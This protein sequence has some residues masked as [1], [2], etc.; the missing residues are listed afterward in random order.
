MPNEGTLEETIKL[1]IS[2]NM[3]DEV[4]KVCTWKRV[5]V[6]AYI[7]QLIEDDLKRQREGRR[8]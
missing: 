8:A 4:K 2:A 6:S 5:G 1:R 3:L 7:R